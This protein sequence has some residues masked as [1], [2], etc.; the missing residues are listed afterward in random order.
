[1]ERTRVGPPAR[2]TE[3]FLAQSYRCHASG[4]GTRGSCRS[5]RR[6]TMSESTNEL[7]ESPRSTDL[8]ASERYGLLASDRRRLA[9]DLLAGRTTPVELRH[10]ATR[11]AAR[12]DAEGAAVDEKIITRVAVTL[13]HVHLPK[14]A[15]AD[16]LDYDADAQRIDP[17]GAARLQP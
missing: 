2:W 3:L 14:L 5:R 9:L 10:L 6:D 4:T 11:V 16:V 13:H 1:M 12:E 8:P 17:N 15:E 7:T